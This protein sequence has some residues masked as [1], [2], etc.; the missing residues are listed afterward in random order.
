MDLTPLAAPAADRLRA[1]LATELPQPEA[2]KTALLLLDPRTG[3]EE[4]RL[5]SPAPDGKPGHET[6]V[7][8]SQAPHSPFALALIEVLHAHR[9]HDWRPARDAFMPGVINMT[10]RRPTGHVGWA[11]DLRHLTEDA[12]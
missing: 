2:I 11:I 10:T 4:V 7:Y 9:L 8:R 6:S 3:H 5:Y 12:E 1:L